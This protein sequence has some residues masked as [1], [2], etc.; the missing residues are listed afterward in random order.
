MQKFEQIARQRSLPLAM[1][2]SGSSSSSSPTVNSCATPN[3][4]A[5]PTQRRRSQ[6]THLMGL[7]PL[8]SFHRPFL[9]PSGRH[10]R[11]PSDLLSHSCASN[12]G[13]LGPS[14][15]PSPLP[16]PCPAARRRTP[17]ARAL[18]APL[19]AA[20]PSRGS[21]LPPRRSGATDPLSGSPRVAVADEPAARSTRGSAGSNNRTSWR[22]RSPS[23]LSR[24]RSGC[25]RPRR[26]PIPKSTDCVVRQV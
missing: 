9:R 7:R 6:V 5:E 19:R 11:R 18:S 22:P 21:A 13:P 4:P 16:L 14:A 20:R 23:R 2:L 12:R 1:L 24:A 26:R 10:G 8:P 25:D 17:E 3:K 15:A